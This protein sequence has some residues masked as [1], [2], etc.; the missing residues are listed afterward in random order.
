MTAPNTNYDLMKG[1]VYYNFNIPL[2]FHYNKH[3]NDFNNKTN[4][5]PVNRRIYRNQT[6]MNENYINKT[7]ENHNN[8]QRKNCERLRDNNV[9]SMSPKSYNSEGSSSSSSRTDSP[10]LSSNLIIVM[11]LICCVN[12]I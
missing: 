9:R 4:P 11:W 6:N 3:N 10:P 5:C 8:W 7:L 1:A 12:V 2:H